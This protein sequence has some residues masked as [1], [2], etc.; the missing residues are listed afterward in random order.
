[1]RPEPVQ[2]HLIMVDSLKFPGLKRR[3]ACLLYEF[4]LM[5]AILLGAV[6]LIT[7]IKATLGPSFWLDQIIRLFLLAVLFAYF[8]LSWIRGGQT[9]AMKAWRLKLVN[10]RAEPIGWGLATLRFVVALMLFIGVPIIAYLGMQGSE[11]KDARLALLWALIPVLYA[12]FDPQAQALHDRLC[13]TRLIL[14]PKPPHR[15]PRTP[16]DVAG[17]E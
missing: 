10:A 15:R 6:A 11:G 13:G 8:G 12:Y 5:A 4:L 9:V 16:R 2:D 14:L 17:E 1:V 3:L 7:P